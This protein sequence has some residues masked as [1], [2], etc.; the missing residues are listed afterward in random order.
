MNNIS[1]VRNVC[2]SLLE[3]PMKVVAF[4]KRSLLTKMISAVALAALSILSLRYIHRFVAYRKVIHLQKELEEAI[5]R[6]DLYCVRNLLND[7]PTLK[8]EKDHHY[9]FLQGS[10]ISVMLPLAAERKC[11]DGKEDLEM[12]QLLCDN[13]ASLN[14]YSI[15]QRNA[16]ESA[17]RCDH[18]AIAH[19]LLDKGAQ[20]DY[21]ALFRYTNKSSCNLELLLRLVEKSENIEANKAFSILGFVGLKYD[22]NPTQCEEIMKLLIDKGDRLTES[23][24][25]FSIPD[26]AIQFIGDQLQDLS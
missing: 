7:H 21:G 14:A 6:G 24:L 10:H 5:E 8:T 4:G 17:L 16:L 22:E 3:I 12:V 23:D 15:M 25:N 1:I 19:Y 26:E 13:G 2:M 11:I 9:P 18:E 20:C